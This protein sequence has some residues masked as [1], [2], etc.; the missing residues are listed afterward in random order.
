MASYKRRKMDDCFDSEQFCR[1][2]KEYNEKYNKVESLNT[3]DDENTKELLKDMEKICFS[4]RSVF[5]NKAKFAL[6]NEKIVA[7]EKEIADIKR[8][9][10]IKIVTQNKI[11]FFSNRKVALDVLRIFD[12]L[13]LIEKNKKDERIEI[14]QK[15]FFDLIS[16]VLAVF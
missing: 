1:M 9:C 6:V 2:A 4:F 13:F 7:L 11:Y 15:K 5:G 16:T 12:K 8:D 3:Q 14:L 10:N